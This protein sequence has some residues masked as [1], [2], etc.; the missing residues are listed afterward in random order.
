MPTVPGLYWYITMRTKRMRIVEI[1]EGGTMSVA[2]NLHC[3]PGRKELPAGW[4]EDPNGAWFH[5]PLRCPEFES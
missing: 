5:G 1:R 4:R 3:F 2:L